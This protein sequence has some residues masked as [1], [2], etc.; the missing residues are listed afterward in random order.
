MKNKQKTLIPLLWLASVGLT[1]LLGALSCATPPPGSP[2]NAQIFLDINNDTGCNVVATLDGA[3]P[4]TNTASGG[5]Y[6]LYTHVTIGQHA[7]SIQGPLNTTSCNYN[8]TGGNQTITVDNPCTA[9]GGS[10]GFT[11]FCN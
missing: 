9:A 6:T 2:S 4:V 11:L 3:N 5:P 10:S 7:V 8:V 1:A